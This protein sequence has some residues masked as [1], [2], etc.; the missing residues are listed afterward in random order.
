[1]TKIE[2]MLSTEGEKALL[3]ILLEILREDSE[4]DSAIFISQPHSGKGTL[5][6]DFVLRSSKGFFVLESKLRQGYTFIEHNDSETVRFCN[7]YFDD[8]ENKFNLRKLDPNPLDQVKNYSRK[9]KET[10]KEI[11][12]GKHAFFN[13]VLVFHP[14][15]NRANPNSQ[16]FFDGAPI[17][18]YHP[19]LKN[20][21]FTVSIGATKKFKTFYQKHKSRSPYAHPNSI[22][23]ALEIMADGAYPKIITKENIESIS[24]SICSQTTTAK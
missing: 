20:E 17:D 2:I 13:S 23:K 24:I 3:E 11:G 16:I 5:R 6:P 8:E 21:Y 10:L 12:Y 1:M 14:C 22:G 15:Q 18:K 4:D 7:V 9:L 19:I